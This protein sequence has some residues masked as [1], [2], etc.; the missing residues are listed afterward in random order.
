[1]KEATSLSVPGIGTFDLFSLFAESAVKWPGAN[2][3]QLLTGLQRL[4][5]RGF[6][7]SDPTDLFL[8]VGSL[9]QAGH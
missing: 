3:V 5:F 2:S 7:L 6:D 8:F 9:C 1:M 4:G